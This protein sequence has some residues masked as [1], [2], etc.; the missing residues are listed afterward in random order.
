MKSHYEEKV[1]DYLEKEKWK[2]HFPYKIRG[3]QPD[4]VIEKN[5]KLAMVEVRGERADF[6]NGV[7]KVLHF[8]NAAN[9]AYLAVPDEIITDK[10]Y[11]ICKS[12]GIGLISIDKEVREI[13]RPESTTALESVKNRVFKFTKKEKP[14]VKKKSLLAVLFRSKTLI[15]L[16]KF[17][18]LNQTQEYYLHELADKAGVSASTALRELNKIQPLNLITK[19]SQGHITYYKINRN[20]IIFEEL[21]RIFLKFELTDE[22]ISK[23]IKKFN[24]KYALIYGSFARGTETE[25][26]DMDLLIIGDVNRH[27]ILNSIS[28]L[29]N[30]IGREI[31]YILWTEKEFK[32]KVQENLSLLKNIKINETIMIQGDKDEFRR[33]IK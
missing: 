16:L 18:L 6:D 17:L 15:Q 33:S 28:E 13:I 29:E 14:V 11:S 25:T 30:T 1:E 27:S 10:V 8:K 2:F 23:E 4:F 3:F 32:E 21:K 31:N 9:Y 24:I 12:L 19:S 5:G 7:K 22:I 20:C 26:S